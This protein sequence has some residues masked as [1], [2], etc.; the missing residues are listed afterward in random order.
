MELRSLQDSSTELDLDIRRTFCRG[1]KAMIVRES[2]RLGNRDAAIAMD[3]G[4]Y[5]WR[6]GFHVFGRFHSS[7]LTF[8]PLLWTDLR[9]FS[10][11]NIPNQYSIFLNSGIQANFSPLTT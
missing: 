5:S 11:P 6:G 4:P 2:A 7:F 1:Q 3:G 9:I 10:P 8:N